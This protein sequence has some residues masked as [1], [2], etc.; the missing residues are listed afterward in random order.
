MDSRANTWTRLSVI[1]VFL[2]LLFNLV[3]PVVATVAP[4]VAPTALR[5][6]VTEAASDPNHVT[7]TL[8]GCRLENGAFIEATVTCEDAAYTSGNLGKEWNELDL[9]PHRLTTQLGSQADATTTYTFG[10]AADREE[11]GAPGYDVLSAPVVNAAKSHASC[12]VTSGP[13]RSS[14]RASAAPTSPSA[15]WSRSPR[16]RARRASSTGTSA[17]RS[18]RTCSRARRCTRTART[19]N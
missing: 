2:A 1:P 13:R 4:Q 18:G 16:T 14:I 7:F 17:W 3:V 19:S 5:P 8:E 6:Q 11:G 9:V 12:Q 10:I 15:A